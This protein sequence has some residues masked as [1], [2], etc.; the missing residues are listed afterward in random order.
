GV[1]T[2]HAHG[3][4]EVRGAQ[5]AVLVIELVD[6]MICADRGEPR[7]CAIRRQCSAAVR[8]ALLAVLR[9]VHLLGV[10]HCDARGHNVLFEDNPER[11]GELRPRLIDFSLG[12]LGPTANEQARD[13]AQWRQVLSV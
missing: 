6:D 4:V 10:A 3:L 12:K 7:R 8:E 11:P 9:E 13:V 2:L 5:Y 1:P